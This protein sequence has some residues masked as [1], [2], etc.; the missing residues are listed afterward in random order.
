MTNTV[1]HVD[2]TKNTFFQFYFPLVQIP[3]CTRANK[4]RHIKCA[5][6]G[7]SQ[8]RKAISVESGKWVRVIRS[9]RFILFIV[10]PPV[11]ACLIITFL[12]VGTMVY[13][14]LY[15]NPFSLG[16]CF[17]CMASVSTTDLRKLGVS[18]IPPP[19]KKNT[20]SSIRPLVYFERIAL[21]IL[22]L[23]QISWTK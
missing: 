23:M 7:G 22:T 2:A 8:K 6:G 15:T 18:Q 16:G 5:G 4:T 20:L 14:W 21:N 12:L 1:V 17:Q 11:S 19:S 13:S 3:S 10:F 9:G